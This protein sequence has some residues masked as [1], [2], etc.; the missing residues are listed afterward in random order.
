MEKFRRWDLDIV[1][2]RKP[3]QGRSWTCPRRCAPKPQFGNMQRMAVDDAFKE[4]EHPFRI[5]I[6]CAMW[7]T[8][9]DVPSH[10]HAVPGQAAEG[11]HADAGH[12]PRQPRQRGQDQRASSWTIAAS[13]STCARALATFAGGGAGA[14]AGG[15]LD[16][17]R[18]AE[19][20]LDGSG[21]GH[22]AGAGLSRRGRVH[23]STACIQS[24]RVSRATQPSWPARKRRTRTTRPASAS[25][26]CAARCS[27]SS[28]ACI[29]V[30]GVNTQRPD[31]D[32]ID[33]DLPQPAAGPGAGRHQRHHP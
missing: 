15:E 32:A 8:G 5:A 30:R 17:A 24:R 27:R 18:P 26:C 28:R 6:V 20:L 2:H 22:R 21:R 16:P 7:L 3:H 13:S 4:Q 29:N 31:R 14:C 19:E 9:F 33:V 11:A 25:R 1:P 12:R 10:L 23:R